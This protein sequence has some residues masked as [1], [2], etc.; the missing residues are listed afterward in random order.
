MTDQLFLRDAYLRHFDATVTA[1]DGDGGGWPSIA[2]PSTQPA[3]ANP[4]T[5]GTLA[6]RAVIEV[7]KEGDQ[8]WHTLD[9][10]RPSRRRRGEGESTGTAVTS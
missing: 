4:T 8:V 3:A 7:R 6:G 2:P 9:G 10:A 1:V 5:P